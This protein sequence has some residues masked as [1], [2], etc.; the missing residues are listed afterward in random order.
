[1]STLSSRDDP[2]EVKGDPDFATHEEN[3]PRAKPV[4]FEHYCHCGKWGLFGYGVRL[5]EDKPG[6][7]FCPEHRP[8]E[9]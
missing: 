7:W 9:A 8:E 6:V 2:R 3:P 4:P 1:M 5:R